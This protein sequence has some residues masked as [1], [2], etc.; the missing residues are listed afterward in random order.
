MKTLPSG[1]QDDLDGGTTTH[2]FCWKITRID[3]EVMGFTDH[4]DDL[5]FDSVTYEASSGFSAT[6]VQ[7]A[8]GMGVD[9]LDVLGA[10]SSAKITEDDISAGL[11]DDA[12]VIIYRVD[13]T[14]TTKRVILLQGSLGEISRSQLGFKSEIRSLAH[15]FNQPIGKTYQKTCGADLGDVR[16]G[17]DT[18]GASYRR[19]T[20]VDQVFSNR[21]IMSDDATLLA[22]DS[23]FFT[24]GKLTWTTGANTG[25]VIEV[26]SHTK[27]TTK[28][29]LDL[30]EVMPYDIAAGDEFTVIVGCNKTIETCFAKFNNVANFRGFPRMPGNDVVQQYVNS[31]D[32][33]D[34]SSLYT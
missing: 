16:C 34:G 28:V 8:S 14:N 26:K 23:A 12:E 20:T 3:A 32:R 15:K 24:G 9:N 13:W 17:F 27:S 4:D 1:M 19:T 30:W 21:Q 22:F 11:Y 7:Q 10:I 31:T 6:A 2:C 33:N 18:S 29:Y 5:S 25:K